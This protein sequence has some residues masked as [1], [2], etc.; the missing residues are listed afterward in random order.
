MAD[1]S[2][3]NDNFVRTEK[4][5]TSSGSSEYPPGR[6]SGTLSKHKLGKTVGG[7]QGKKKY[8]V[9]QYRVCSAH[10]KCGKRR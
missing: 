4:T 5:S 7:G 1:S 2:S 6:L 8:P 3:D 9:R 10:K